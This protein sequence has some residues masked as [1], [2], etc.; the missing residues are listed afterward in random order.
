MSDDAI[1]ILC[2]VPSVEVGETLGRSLVEARLAACVNV[3][4]GLRSIYRWKGEVQIDAEAQCLIKTRASL[5][6]RVRDHVLA[7]HPYE[8]PEIVALPV[9][10]GS[11]GYLAWIASETA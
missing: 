6:E 1:V 8:T 5:F 2:T 11:D 4:P 9:T 10:R 3:I 7:N